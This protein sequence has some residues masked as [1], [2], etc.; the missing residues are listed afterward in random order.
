MRLFSRKVGRRRYP[1]RPAAPLDSGESPRILF[2]SHEATRTGAPK[3]ALQLLRHLGGRHEVVTETMFHN[4]GGMEGEFRRHGPTHTVG[5]PR[6]HD[7]GLSRKVSKIVA[8]KMGGVPHLA[9]CNSMES[10]FIAKEL[11]EYQIPI[12][13]LVH[14]LPSSYEPAD[15]C[16]VFD[17]S[18][19]VIFPVETVRRAVELKTE[20]PSEKSVVLPQGLLDS[21][22][23][24]RICHEQA[25]RQI[26]QE[27]GL[28][29]KAKI[30]LGCGTLDLRKGIDHFTQVARQFLSQ[31]GDPD[32]H[33]IWVGDGP[34][35]TH[36]LHHYL[37]LDIEKTNVQ[38]RIH[39]IGERE[40]VEPYFVGSD[41]FLLTSR[42]D[43]FPCVVHE[44]MAAQLPVV[45]FDQ[46]GGASEAIAD[47]A[48]VVIA[49]A[50]HRQAAAALQQLMDDKMHADRIRQRGLRRVS[51]EYCFD[52]YANQ[53]QSM[54][55]SVLGQPLSARNQARKAA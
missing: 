46:S 20:I 50:D 5:L 23:G 22:F 35:W 28:S 54:V 30:V 33:F 49:Y 11:A 24:T 55:E 31:S 51:E 47:G 44:A 25:K 34:Q 32:V 41:A 10:R 26:C 53:I 4:G 18:E 9:I 37:L 19:R 12:L 48:G 52:R 6:K 3:I 36:S 16:D 45:A 27:L 14:E 17:V 43:P 13:F 38:D 29:E 1:V 42:V 8:R 7:P 21:Q 40:D 39:F 15:Y 2:V